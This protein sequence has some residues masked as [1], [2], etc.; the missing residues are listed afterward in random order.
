MLHVEI[1]LCDLWIPVCCIMRANSRQDRG[2]DWI[3]RLP[4]TITPNEFHNLVYARMACRSSPAPANCVETNPRQ[5]ESAGRDASTRTVFSKEEYLKAFKSLA[6]SPKPSA[7]W[8]GSNWQRQKA[9]SL[10]NHTVPPAGVVPAKATYLDEGHANYTQS[11]HRSQ[12]ESESG[13]PDTFLLELQAR[14][15]DELRKSREKQQEKQRLQKEQAKTHSK[16][17]RRYFSRNCKDSPLHSTEQTDVVTCLAQ[18]LQA[19]KAKLE[20][21]DKQR[22]LDRDQAKADLECHD[23]KMQDLRVKADSIRSKLEQAKVCTS[24]LTPSVPCIVYQQPVIAHC[25]LCRVPST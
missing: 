10:L 3:G 5:D 16:V 14:R 4:V 7:S 6:V 13:P 19:K 24:C 17:S 9:E 12:T 21:K 2:A 25:T 11:K 22:I 20:A 15:R 23:R 1:K 8:L 18:L